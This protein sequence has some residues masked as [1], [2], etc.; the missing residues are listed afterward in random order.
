MREPACPNRQFIHIAYERALVNPATVLSDVKG[1]TRR[2]CDVGKI[3]RNAVQITV[4]SALIEVHLAV[5]AARHRVEDPFAK[6]GIVHAQI[7]PFL[8][9]ATAVE[10]ETGGVMTFF[11]EVVA[12]CA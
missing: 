10:H 4:A 7:F 5:R 1:H 8:S 6:F 12:G 3:V 9:L 11:L 2:E